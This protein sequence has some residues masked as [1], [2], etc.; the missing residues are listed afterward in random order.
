MGSRKR[1]KGYVLSKQRRVAG[2]DS[3]SSVG[4]AV[5]MLNSC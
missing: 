4:A 3:C 5:G 2:L 1:S